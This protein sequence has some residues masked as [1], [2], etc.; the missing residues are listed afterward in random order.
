MTKE[1]K[2]L[3][4]DIIIVICLLVLD[5][6]TK[7]LARTYLADGPIEIVKGVFSFT[8][9]QGGNSGAAFGMMQGGFWLFMI[10]TAIVVAADLWV[11]IKIP[12][13]KHFNLLR[14]S[15]VLLL[16][17]AFGNCIDRIVTK[18]STGVSSVTDFM[19]FELIDFPIFNVADICVTFAAIF[20]IVSGVFVYKDKDF[21]LVFKGH[22]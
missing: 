11:L 13:E 9:L 16:A 12:A 5:Q 3:I 21:N 7:Y 14:L 4:T 19:Y 6:I 2:R 1:R 8:L 17:G 22:E 18:I 20:L 15:L 10:A